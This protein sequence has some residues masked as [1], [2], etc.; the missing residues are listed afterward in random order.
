MRP[1]RH[2]LGPHGE[3]D[4]FLNKIVG[5]LSRMAPHKSPR[6]APHMGNQT[7]KLFAKTRHGCCSTLHKDG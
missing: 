6:E 3:N 5:D 2:P 4:R 7:T 1:A